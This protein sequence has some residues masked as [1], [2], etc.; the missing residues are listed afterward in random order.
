[1][2]PVACWRGRIVEESFS[3]FENGPSSLVPQVLGMP[4][5]FP[6][7]QSIV[8]LGCSSRMASGRGTLAETVL[9]T[10]PTG[11]TLLH[12]LFRFAQ[13]VASEDDLA[14]IQQ[15][16][17][18]EVLTCI[19]DT[20]IL[21]ND[22]KYAVRNRR[23]TAL[24]DAAA[25]G[26]VRFFA[27][28]TVRDEVRDWLP[29]FAD[30]QKFDATDALCRWEHEYSRFITFVDPRGLPFVSQDVKVLAQRDPDDVATGLLIDYF[31]PHAVLS[32]DTKHLSAFR[33]TDRD[34]TILT[35][36]YRDKSHGDA[37]DIG[38][39]FGAGGVYWVS[40]EVLRAVFG[41]VRGLGWRTLLPVCGAL[42]AL[43][44]G[45][46]M[47][48][49]ARSALNDARR[50]L[51]I[52]AVPAV[53]VVCELLE[54]YTRVQEAHQ[55]ARRILS[56]RKLQREE[57][58]PV[59]ALGYV[60][61]V[62]AHAPGPL[63]AREISRRMISAGYTPQGRIPHRYVN[64]LLHRN[65]SKLFEQGERGRWQV[66]SH[67]GQD[68]FSTLYAN[69]PGALTPEPVREGVRRRSPPL[70]SD[71]ASDARTYRR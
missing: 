64:Q 65:P 69:C 67:Q 22:L 50:T 70:S 55:K 45:A 10:F 33:I 9:D 59:R 49:A 4:H 12:L 36:A 23:V 14:A 54:A 40:S 6:D 17:R 2:G 28:T 53:S 51:W 56:E 68:D 42:I 27:S 38:V 8:Q 31:R 58:R 41:I 26:S 48:P 32:W 60:V 19:L 47:I 18:I 61:D 63:S 62:L 7:E 24:M 3:S 21:L 29:A 37:I 16:L 11:M 44:G 30:K 43:I 5:G 15:F 25:Y 1:M 35:C 13:L 39:Y 34:W 46:L 52:R 66:K 57:A 20:N 71:Q